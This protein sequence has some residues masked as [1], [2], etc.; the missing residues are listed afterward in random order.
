MNA[1]SLKQPKIDFLA[2]PAHVCEAGGTSLDLVKRGR[3]RKRGDGGFV[4]RF[5]CPAC[6]TF[7]SGGP[8]E[9]LRSLH[10]PGDAKSV[11][12]LANA[13]MSIEAIAER[14]D[15][16][17]AAVRG[18]FAKLEAAAIHRYN[19][20]PP[21]RGKGYGLVC[22]PL[23]WRGQ[24]RPRVIVAA[25]GWRRTGRRLIDWVVV[26]PGQEAEAEA[27][28]DSRYG[29]PTVQSNNTIT[30]DLNWLIECLGPSWWM[31]RS[32]ENLEQR[33]WLILAGTHGWN[34]T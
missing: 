24:R 17:S 11:W 5:W 12:K 23:T 14:L 6:D 16:S 29:E 18:R 27:D 4:Q 8:L 2:R 20:H 22:A 25:I 1:P 21:G 33:L 3:R 28:L 30:Q 32:Q 13:G 10:R 26:D 15:L 34:L 9:Y 19:I 31:T 7:L